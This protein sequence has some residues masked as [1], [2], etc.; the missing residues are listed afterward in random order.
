[1]V[2]PSSPANGLVLRNSAGNSDSQILNLAGYS[3]TVEHS[4]RLADD[5]AETTAGTASILLDADAATVVI[6][7]SVIMDAPNGRGP[8]APA[9]GFNANTNI[10]IDG[11]NPGMDLTVGGNWDVRVVSRNS[12]NL[13]YSTLTMTGDAATFELADDAT[14]M[15]ITSGIWAVGLLNIGTGADDAGL[16]LVNDY[17]NDN[18]VTGDEAVDKIGE[19]LIVG[20]L[21]MT[22]G[23]TLDLNTGLSLSADQ[24]IETML[25]PGDQTG[26]WLPLAGQ[27]FDSTNPGVTFTAVYDGGDD[28]TYWQV[29]VIPEPTT[30]AL[31]AVGAAAL[32]KRR[33]R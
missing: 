31:L 28:A 19:K 9:S 17:I 22:A 2:T 21:A 4:V 27:V 33:D 30:M 29:D 18:P 13:A 11:G 5:A 12:S 32:L 10:G 15:T 14:Q 1:M 8:E 23:S 3:L 25:S 24:I 6:K 16:Q 7:G 20:D 26:T